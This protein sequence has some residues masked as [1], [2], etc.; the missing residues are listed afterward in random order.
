M[1]IGALASTT[2]CPVGVVGCDVDGFQRAVDEAMAGDE[3]ILTP[4]EYDEHVT[5]RKELTIIGDGDVV[6]TG[7]GY[8][9]AVLGIEA[10]VRV[11]NLVIDGLTDVSAP[12]VLVVDG[13]VELDGLRLQGGE[14]AYESAASLAVKGGEVTMTDG[15][16]SG[17]VGGAIVV[18]GGGVL[19]VE[20]TA[21]ED[22][23]DTLGGAVLAVLD[24]GHATLRDTPVSGVS[25]SE[26]ARGGLF[27]VG[28]GT[29]VLEGL[30][31]TG[32]DVLSG[33]V[34]SVSGGSL[35]VRETTLTGGVADYGGLIFVEGG[36]L[37]LTDSVLRDSVANSQGGAVYVSGSSADVQLERCT[38]V[39]NRGDAGGAVFVEAAEEFDVLVRDSVFDRNSARDGGAL[40]V[41]GEQK[42]DLIGNVFSGNLAT[43]DGAGAV[44]RGGV[45][46]AL[47][48][49]SNLFCDNHAAKGSGGG[50]NLGHVGDT[51]M[52]N[53]VFAKNSAEEG[54]GVEVTSGDLFAEFNTFAGNLAWIDGAAIQ[55]IEAATLDTSHGLYV[56][57]TSGDKVLTALG[58][59]SSS[60]NGFFENTVF[61]TTHPSKTD[62]VLPSDPGFFSWDLAD[63]CA[64]DARVG[65][66]SV[67]VDVG[68]PTRREADGSPPDLGATGGD[69]IDRVSDADTDGVPDLFDCAPDDAARYPG[70]PEVCNGQDD[71]C[72]G[73]VDDTVYVWPDQDGDGFGDADGARLEVCGEVPGYVANDNDCDDDNGAKNPAAAEICNGQDDNCDDAIDE[74]LPTGVTFWSDSDGDGYGSGPGDT[75][76]EAPADAVLSGDDCDDTR[77]DVFPGAP[78]SCDGVDHDC[79]GEANEPESVDAS[80]VHLDG[81]GD[82]FGSDETVRSC[83]SRV[84][85]SAGGDCD[86]TDARVH[87]GAGEVWYDDIDQDCDGR[88][89]FDA[90]LDGF[91]AWGF[92]GTDCDDLDSSSTPVEGAPDCDVLEET[93]WVGG[94][95]GCETGG[96][97]IPGALGLTLGLLALRRRR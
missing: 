3:L 70:A 53:N 79:D 80:V 14:S 28:G 35:E 36:A 89:D 85:V 1:S 61:D 27:S 18:Q 50:L 58:E 26:S 75:G 95:G 32:L 30:N 20:G 29:L 16:I 41:D 46:V 43:E 37:T 57:N 91:D 6:I 97:G 42:I 96:G 38:F 5:I 69:A 48:V 8:P 9:S 92:G 31:L 93:A 88:S 2:V 59:A 86:D 62:R 4:G 64:I 44:I 22:V 65:P 56:G 90:D 39:S 23:E 25:A 55:T 33:G 68:D 87:P 51:N 52:L 10:D 74:G 47:L 21:F 15:T 49:Q 82:G 78:E 13:D 63:P 77:S 76:C 54:G 45:A 83:D 67:I 40:H 19:V 34:A 81:D 94:G 71:D 12:Q 60:W 73:I 72:D 7:A 17:A 84:G 24:S 11:E 66:D